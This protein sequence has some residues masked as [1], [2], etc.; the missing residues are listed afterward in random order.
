MKLRGHV[1]TINFGL[2]LPQW[3][4]TVERGGGLPKLRVPLWG[5]LKIWI[6][7]FVGVYIGAL[8][9]LGNYQVA[10][11][12]WTL[13]LSHT[14][15]SPYRRLLKNPRFGTHQTQHMHSYFNLLACY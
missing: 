12:H 2:P 15:N 13:S 3:S 9:V 6:T 4:C 7:L 11:C 10:L 14:V 5:V 8:P 1:H